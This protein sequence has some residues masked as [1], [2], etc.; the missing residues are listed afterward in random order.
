[1][2]TDMR[3]EKN[4]QHKIMNATTLLL[5]TYLLADGEIFETL[6]PAVR[7]V[8][9]RP[10][11]DPAPVL[12]PEFPWETSMHFYGSAV[13]VA[14]NDL[15]IY[16][17]CNAVGHH[18][19]DGAPDG[20]SSCCVAV[21]ADNG[22][23][24]TRPM[25]QGSVPYNNWT[26]T[27]MVFTSGGGW[28]D[29]MLLLPLGMP[30]PFPRGAPAGTRFVM[31]FDDGVSDPAGLRVLQL[32][33]SA[34]GFR[35]T[36]LSP[37]M[38][39]KDS[40]F[41][42]TSV[43][44]SFDPATREFVAFGRYDG[45]PNQHPERPQC[46]KQIPNFNM[47]SVRAV[48]RATSPCG[49]LVNFSLAAHVPLHFDKLDDQCVDVYNTAAWI[50]SAGVRQ[51]SND[52]TSAR[53]G[54]TTERA[55]L[56]FPAFYQHYG[57][58]VNDGVLDVRFMFSRDGISFR[59]IGGDRRAF[60]PRG[61]GAAAGK[62]QSLFD[63]E[64]GGFP[65]QW[66]AGIAYMYRGVIDVGD[67]T[68][69]MYYFGQQGSHAHQDCCS[70]GKFGIGRARILKDR[71]IALALDAPHAGPATNGS[72]ANVTMMTQPVLL[73]SCAHIGRGNATLTMTL[74][75]EV[76]VGG[77]VSMAVLVAETSTPVPGFSHAEA[78]TIYGNRLAAPLKFSGDEG[79]FS[80]LPAVPLRLQFILRA[81]ARVFAWEFHCINV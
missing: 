48:R 60:I 29:S 46:G 34:D 57:W 53:G 3:I 20:P 21:S 49:S 51:W 72:A 76:S 11:K 80:L 5:G 81:P 58:T 55:Y 71:W 7:A 30:A 47:Q 42:D 63:E 67:G 15:R 28:F 18:D 2:S 69:E 8:V 45:Y 65:A 50:A 14:P 62:E 6:D 1:M 59:Y 41:A 36:V 4:N 70:R 56:A 16:Y 23:T 75:V 61:I 64:E 24:W 52:S 68:Q 78:L 66:D 74:N 37:P 35:F 19:V 44:L 79:N 73:P 26:R 25:L 10:V 12:V 32:A 43:S 22:T 39:S 13:A 27:N 40:S 33:V 38:A 9:Q 77:S 54:A 17:A 31:A